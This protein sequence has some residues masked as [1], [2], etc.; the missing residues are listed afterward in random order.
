MTTANEGL[1]VNAVR[2]LAKAG[3]LTMGAYDGSGEPVHAIEEARRGVITESP[4]DPA[5]RCSI[6]GAR[7]ADRN[8]SINHQSD[9]D[10]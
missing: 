10:R 4:S 5:F 9:H 2:V 3:F 6:C 7:F 8:K 1:V